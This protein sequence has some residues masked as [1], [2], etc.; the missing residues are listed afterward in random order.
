MDNFLANL[1]RRA[2]FLGQ[3]DAATPPKSPTVSSASDPPK[4]DSPFPFSS[5]LHALT[6]S[7]TLAIASATTVHDILPKYGLPS[8]L[9]PDNVK[10]YSLSSDGR[11]VVDLDGPCYIQFDYL[12]YYDKKISGKLSYGSI[13]DLKGIQVQRFLLWLS[14]DEIRVDLPPADCIYFQVGLINKKLDV[15]QFETVRSCRDKKKLSG[16]C[17]GSW[18]RVFELAGPAQE[19]PMLIT[20]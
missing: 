15:D 20:E 6:L 2:I 1:S 13:T 17:G 8:G 14:V 5:L 19:V 4:M 18:T 10:S 11:F 12:V 16:N 9:L 7:L 3:L